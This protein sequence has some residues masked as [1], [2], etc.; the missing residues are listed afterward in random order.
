M[1]LFETIA[2]HARR[3]RVYLQLLALAIEVGRR[4]WRS[5]RFRKVR[6]DLACGTGDP[7]STGLAKGLAEAFAGLARTRCRAFH[8][9]M[10]PVFGRTKVDV[11]GEVELSVAPARVLIALLAV[12]WSALRKREL[13]R[14]A[15]RFLKEKIT[16]LFAS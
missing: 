11:D 7:A 6:L 9:R 12:G 8:L 10:T 2:P 13:R 15:Y 4:L 1:S 14:F 5:V 3:R 16:S